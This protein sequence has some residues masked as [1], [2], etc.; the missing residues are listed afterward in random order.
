[1]ADHPL[2]S[3]THRRLGG[4]L[5]HQPANAPQAHP[6]VTAKRPPFNFPTCVGKGY[7]VLATVSRGYPGLMGRL[8][9]CYSPVRHS[10]HRSKLLIRA[11]D[12]HVLGTPP[13][14]ILSQDQTLHNWKFSD[15]VAVLLVAQVNAVAF[16]FIGINVD[17]LSFSFQC[18][19]F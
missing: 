1:M 6:S 4:P 18:S 10:R 9:T 3:A 5:P 16:V 2:R 13:A 14:F 19:L 7:P 15:S 8:P 11:F 12:L 17:I